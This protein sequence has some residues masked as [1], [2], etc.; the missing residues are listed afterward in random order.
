MSLCRSPILIIVAG[1]L[2]FFSLSASS[3]AIDCHTAQVREHRA[4]AMRG[5]RAAQFRL[6]EALFWGTGVPRDLGN[7]AEWYRRAA[8]QD[9]VAAQ[10]M[11]GLM[12]VNGIGVKKNREEGR[13][14]MAIAAESG[15]VLAKANLTTL[16][17]GGT[18]VLRPDARSSV[19]PLVRACDVVSG[20]CGRFS[21]RTLHALS[22]S[23][24]QSGEPTARV[25]S[26]QPCF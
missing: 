10:I 12:L 1:V 3:I 4:L 5:D 7:A 11:T 22:D 24:P 2:A 13:R 17:D 18:P 14:W 21:R 25:I 8:E 26:R 6:A 20:R 15:D 16:N 23:S 19:R 9:I